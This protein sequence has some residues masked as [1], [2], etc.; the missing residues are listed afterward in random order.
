MEIAA[1]ADVL[2]SLLLRRLRPDRLR[3]R[4]HNTTHTGK[5]QSEHSVQS[6]SKFKHNLALLPPKGKVAY[7]TLS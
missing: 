1:G 6:Q 5:S 7:V 4:L 3:E 2:M